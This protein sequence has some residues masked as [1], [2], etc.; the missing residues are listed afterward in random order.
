MKPSFV[1]YTVEAVFGIVF[2]CQG[3]V[4]VLESEKVPRNL[5]DK[6]PK[7]QKKKKDFLEVSPVKKHAKIKDRKLIL[8][9]SDGSQIAVD[10]KGCIVEAVSATSLPSRKW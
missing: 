2:A 10:L 4:W 3:V 1:C 6:G 5:V 9:E 8:F 7:E